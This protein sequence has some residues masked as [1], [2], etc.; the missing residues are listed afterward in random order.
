MPSSSRFIE[1]INTAYTRPSSAPARTN[2]VLTVSQ[3]DRSNS[4]SSGSGS[5]LEQKTRKRISRLLTKPT[6]P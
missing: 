6:K 4:G 1:H 5:E 2:D 3:K